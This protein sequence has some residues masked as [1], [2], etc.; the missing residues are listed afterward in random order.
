MEGD[1]I[2][3]VELDAIAKKYNKNENSVTPN[4][5]NTLQK[6]GIVKEDQTIHS[7]NLIKVGSCLDKYERG[8]A[9]YVVAIAGG[10]SMDA[11]YR[12][13]TEGSGQ[14]EKNFNE[15]DV[16]YESV[17][18]E[19]IKDSETFKLHVNKAGIIVTAES[20]REHLE[21]FLSTASSE[22]KAYSNGEIIIKY[23]NDNE[24]SVEHLIAAGTM[25]LDAILYCSYK[26]DQVVNGIFKKI[27]VT[28]L[29]PSVMAQNLSLGKKSIL[30]ATALVFITGNLP[31]KDLSD[32]RP[33]PK[34]I[35]NLYNSEVDK[36]S[37]IAG[38]LSVADPKKFPAKAFL[39]I[40]LNKIDVATASRCKL[41]I[42]GN[43]AVRYADYI[44]NFDQAVIPGVAGK[45]D[46][47]EA[48][49]A[50]KK[51]DR[52]ERARELTEFLRSLVGNVKAQLRMHPLSADKPTVKNL[53]LKLTRACLESLS[54]KGR[55]EMR[56]KIVKNQNNSFKSDVNFFGMGEGKDAHWPLIEN[57]DA[58]FMDISVV[59]LKAIYG[60]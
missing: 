7:Q 26:N 2:K 28:E 41:S 25:V 46:A 51:K 32:S 35:R 17:G 4:E 20:I 52:V 37:T 45:L 31:P 13:K 24:N 42:A 30:S 53:T 19:K 39:N 43:K 14:K 36:L 55:L 60:V 33:V 21:K 57:V 1:H 59:G 18:E 44:G 6:F 48:T 34:F 3:I 5:L 15:S 50:V 47:D 56:E 49:R 58:D 11:S 27:M 8:G 29:K 23:F 10:F 54:L 22:D 9:E 12:P 16:T 38:Y 40:D